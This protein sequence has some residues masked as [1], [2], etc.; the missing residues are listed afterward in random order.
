MGTTRLGGI[1]P[2]V[3]ILTLLGVV[4]VDPAA[5]PLL[6]DLDDRHNPCNRNVFRSHRRTPM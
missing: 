2:V 1:G 5:L 3:R 4:P 6:L